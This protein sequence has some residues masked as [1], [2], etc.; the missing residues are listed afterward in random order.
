MLN[1]TPSQ[2]GRGGATRERLLDAAET[3]MARNGIDAVSSRQI[4]TAIGQGNNSALQ[5]H[6]GDK[7]ALVTAIVARRVAALEPRRKALLSQ[8]PDHSTDVRAFLRVIFL[9]LAEAV[10]AEGRHVYAA[11][12]LQFLNKGQYEFGTH[13]PGWENDSAALAATEHLIQL[14]PGLGR[15]RAGLRLRYLNGLFLNALVERDNARA[16]GRPMGD[17]AEAL[18]ELIDMM[19]A[20]FDAPSSTG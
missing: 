5:Y 13:H 11:F 20:A 2:L 17:D 15:E 19:A 16:H 3:L 10:D 1:P 14:R 7:A 8:V 9:P 12:L 4:A 6:F 18:V